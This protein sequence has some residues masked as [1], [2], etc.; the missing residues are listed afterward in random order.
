M[1]VVLFGLGAVVVGVGVGMGTAHLRVG[2]TASDPAALIEGARGV[3]PP[4]NPDEPQP[5]LAIDETDFDF[6]VMDDDATMRHEFVF[7]NEGPGTLT[8]TKGDTTCRCTVVDLR[9]TQ[10]A[11]GKS[12]AITIEWNSK[13]QAGPYRQSATVYTNDPDRPRVTLTISGQVRA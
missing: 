13:N 12:A 3:R 6:G 5:T 1:K 10:V 4:P 11:P 9:E 8:L 7:R 2:S